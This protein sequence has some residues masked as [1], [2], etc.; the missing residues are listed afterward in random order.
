MRDDLQSLIGA[1]SQPLQPVPTGVEPKLPEIQGIRAVLFDVYGTLLI[2]ASGDVASAD[3]EVRQRAF[4][5]AW[6]EGM[7]SRPPAAGVAALDDAIKE[8]HS[9]DRGRGVDYPEV[10]IVAMWRQV[11]AEAREAAE[12]AAPSASLD[13][14]QLDLPRLAVEFEVRANPVWPMPGLEECL[15]Q[16]RHAGLV[17]GI[18]S[19]AQFFTPIALAAVTGK[20]VAEHG[21]DPDLQYYSY[22]FARAKPSHVMYE[23]AAAALADRG[24][25]ASETLF[26][27]NDMRN[28]I[29]PAAAVGFRTALFAGDRRSLRMRTDEAESKL[30]PEADAVVTELVQLAAILGVNARA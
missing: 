21:F 22:E 13:V 14:E 20:S 5:D 19:N 7:G 12:Q 9:H 8:Q 26:V 28:D 18:I 23:T 27:G 10:D 30:A 3:P 24:I 11:A 16:L 2:S 15:Q 25:A 1:A 17:L 6:Q 29:W 4:G